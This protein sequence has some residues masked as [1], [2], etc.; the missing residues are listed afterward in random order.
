[1]GAPAHLI[2][3]PAAPRFM[4]PTAAPAFPRRGAAVQTTAAPRAHL[5]A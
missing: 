3:C 4:G 2:A 1:M 5:Y